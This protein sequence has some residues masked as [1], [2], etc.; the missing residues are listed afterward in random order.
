MA[1]SAS[2]HPTELELAILKVLWKQSPQTVEEV[3]EV[4]AAEGRELTHSSVI[5]IMNIMVRKESL[6]RTKNGR[7][8]EF[9]PLVRE[10]EV[11]RGMLSDLVERVFDGSASTLMLRLLETSDIDADEL[12][13][14]RK[15]IQKAQKNKP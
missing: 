2:D 1:R 3:R 5:T 9:S 11:G 6:E 13:E 8:F 4:L 12:A 10:E 7:A 15:L 14:I